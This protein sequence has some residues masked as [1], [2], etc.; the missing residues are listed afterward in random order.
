MDINSI[1]KKKRNRQE[2]KE[3]EIKLFIGKYAKGEVSEAQAGALLSYIYINGL[4]E[5]E[6][7]NFAK[8]MAFSGEILDLSDVSGQIVDK[9]STGG[10]GDKVT[11]ILIPI[12]AALNLPVAKVSSRG[13]GITGGTIDKLEAIPGFDTQ[14]NLEEFK[15]NI[16]KV[17]ASIINQNFNIAPA[18]KKMYKLRNEVACND[19]IPL[20]AASLL[21]LKIATGSNKIAFDI[22]CGKGTYLKSKEE[23]K[24]L[25]KLLVR[26]GKKID[27]DIGCVITTMDE[28]LGYAIGDTLEII[29]TINSL[30]GKMPQDVGDVVVALGSLI[31]KLS[32]YG[33]DLNKN[34]ETIV[35]VIQSGKA[36]EKFKEIVA[37]QYGSLEYVE[38]VEKFKKAQYI[39][40][41]YA[42]ETGNIE[43]IDADIIGSIAKYLGAG[44]MKNAEDVDKTAG[45]VLNKKIGDPV[46]IGEVMA[47]IHANDEQ[48]ALSSTKILEEAFKI[49]TKKIIMGSRIVEII[50]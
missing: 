15:D 40:P 38:N 33:D 37:A 45:I 20:I 10:V 28:P 5:N 27:K 21:S 29:E 16:K 49:T 43:K 41:V 2:L 4:T 26:L 44:R 6:I 23:A 1:I 9:H 50:K 46:Q 19:S 36:Y 14:M 39:I 30:K 22:T 12:I 24:R 31:L 48:K 17:G 13:L 25:A 47:T 3:E 42:T 8:E 35:D 32:G 18:E 11:L 34:A 7:I